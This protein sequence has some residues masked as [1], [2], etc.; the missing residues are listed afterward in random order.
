MGTSYLKTLLYLFP[1]EM[2]TQ[3]LSVVLT[4]FFNP[5]RGDLN[6]TGEEARLLQMHFIRLQCMLIFPEPKETLQVPSSTSLK[7]QTAASGN[8]TNL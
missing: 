2:F 8:C 1:A 3:H 6:P 7:I 5:K 4:L